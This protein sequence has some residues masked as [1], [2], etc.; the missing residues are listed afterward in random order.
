MLMF[1][2][3]GLHQLLARDVDMFTDKVAALAKEK[4]AEKKRSLAFVKCC[5]N[6]LQTFCTHPFR[7]L[8]STN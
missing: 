1:F 7:R 5:F 6:F 2:Y 3:Q 4:K 8:T